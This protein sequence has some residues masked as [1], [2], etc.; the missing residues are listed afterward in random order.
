MKTAGI[1]KVSKRKVFPTQEVMHRWANETQQEGRNA[2]GNC[3]FEGK[4]L[5]SYG[6]H[7]EMGRHVTGRKGEK[8]VLLNDEGSSVTTEKHK[9]WARQSIPGDRVSFQAI[10]FDN[11]GVNLLYMLDNS[12]KFLDQASRAR[13]YKVSLLNRAKK[14]KE[15]A[16]KYFHLFGDQV[17]LDTI[18]IYKAFLKKWD[19][20]KFQLEL[21]DGEAKAVRA[22]EK[23]KL[24]DEERAKK[25]EVQRIERARQDEENLELWKA[26]EN[27]QTR[28]NWHDKAFLRVKGEQVETSQGARVNVK[29]ARV[30]YKMIL[31]GKEI[32]TFD[33]EGFKVIGLTDEGQSLKIGCHT[34]ELT[35]I[36]RIGEELNKVETE[37]ETTLV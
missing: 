15:N 4:S 20:K 18:K 32:R 2:Q 33:L 21:I 10:D 9:S 29:A 6:S 30:L 24:V 12:K 19:E 31:A 26:G 11:L 36:H 13:V 5:F 8:V 3:Y 35:E 7:Y 16:I 27:I 34:I 23:R 17:G 1:K 25:W 37:Q 14:E 28:F 22:N